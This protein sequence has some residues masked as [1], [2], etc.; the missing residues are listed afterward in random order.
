MWTWELSMYVQFAQKQE[1]WEC[2]CKGRIRDMVVNSEIFF[3][4]LN[5]IVWENLSVIIETEWKINIPSYLSVLLITLIIHFL[6]N[7]DHE[8]L[9]ISTGIASF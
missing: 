9:N 5:W 6:K 3:T 2:V 7:I 4:Y 8:L 1:N